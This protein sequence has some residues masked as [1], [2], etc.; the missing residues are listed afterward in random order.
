MQAEPTVLEAFWNSLWTVS[1]ARL[2]T[3][4]GWLATVLGLV[5]S[6]RAFRHAERAEMAA[7]NAETAAKEAR[8]QIL[9][10]NTTEELEAICLKAEELHDF[11]AQDRFSEARLRTKEI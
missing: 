7:K 11:F 5:Y 10:K 4:S 3:L 9:L 1:Q 8:H 2:L 6:I